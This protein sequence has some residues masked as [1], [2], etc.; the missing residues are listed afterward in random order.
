M[1]EIEFDEEEISKDSF[2]TPPKL[3]KRE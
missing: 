3:T 2:L 1:D